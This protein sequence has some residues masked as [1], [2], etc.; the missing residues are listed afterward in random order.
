MK[1]FLCELLSNLKP[2]IVRGKQ[3]DKSNFSMSSILFISLFKLQ[4]ISNLWRRIALTFEKGSQ[5]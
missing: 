3:I 2:N 4:H 1:A 5:S